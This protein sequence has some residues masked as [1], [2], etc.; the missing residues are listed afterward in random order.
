MARADDYK[1]AVQ[2]A[3]TQLRSRDPHHVCRLAG[4][5]CTEK[6]G[7]PCGITLT[8]LGRTIT[9]S[10]P[11]LAFHQDSDEEIS[12]KQR[13]IILHYLNGA[14]EEGPR[15]DWISFQDIPSARF[16]LDAFNRRVKSPLIAAFG[17]HPD[18]L[19]SVAQE[20]FGAT[21]ASIGDMSVQIQALP[22]V[23]IILVI[24]KGDEEFSSDGTLLFDRSIKDML[25]AEDISELTSQIVYPLIAKA[26]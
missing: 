22:K 24:W 16:Y 14:Q 6:G 5:L 1:E 23:P 18:R 17:D 13:I 19:L 12:I 25:S 4:A 20:L 2:I 15:G 10:W 3:S 11:D 8:F 7:Q 21:R 9:M 26:Q